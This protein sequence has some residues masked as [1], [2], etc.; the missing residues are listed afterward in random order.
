MSHW[1]QPHEQWP[2]HPKPWWRETIDLARS[3]EWHLQIV[4]GHAWGRIVCDPEMDK[5]CRI[6]IFSSGTGGESAAL[7]ARRTIQRCDHPAAAES[8]RILLR[9]VELLDRA[10]ALLEAASRCLR[11]SGKMAEAEEL[12]LSAVTAADEAEKLAQALSR[13]EDSNRL[14]VAAFEVLPEGSELG[15][16]PTEV[17]VEALIINASAHADEAQQLADDLPVKNSD[18]VLQ[19]RIDQVRARVTDLS[20][21]L[22]QGWDANGSSSA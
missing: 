21:Q 20:S 4:E 3:A 12:L 9:V 1:Y 8:G 2:R 22:G 6:L 13:E 19:V 7:T 14:V 10:E 15:C 17:Q 5:P 18:D 11:A 16:P